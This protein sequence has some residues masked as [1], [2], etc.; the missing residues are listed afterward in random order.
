[1]PVRS[2]SRSRQTRL[3]QRLVAVGLALEEGRIGEQRGRHRL[4]RQRDA[5]LLDHVGLG[6]EI[7]V[8]LHRAGP[9]HHGFPSVPTRSM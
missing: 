4:Q 1:M 7:E 8:H 5:E 6:R 2:A 3:R 9:V